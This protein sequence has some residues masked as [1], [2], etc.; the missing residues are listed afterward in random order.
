MIIGSILLDLLN[1]VILVVAA[2]FSILYTLIS[3]ILFF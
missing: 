1:A 2:P 3:A